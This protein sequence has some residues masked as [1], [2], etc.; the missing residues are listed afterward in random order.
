MAEAMITGLLSGEVVDAA[1]IIAS[2]P[3]AERREELEARHGVR[4]TASNPEAVEAAVKELQKISKPTKDQREIAQV[5]T[6]SANN[7]ETIGDLIARAL[8]APTDEAALAGLGAGQV[9]VP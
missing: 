5:G 7:D 8:E 3:R 4:T 6:I 1:Q 9:F 2:E